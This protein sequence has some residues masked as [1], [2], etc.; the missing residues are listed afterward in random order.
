MYQY[1]A[2][3]SCKR[4]RYVAEMSHIYLVR[5]R[6]KICITFARIL[7][8]YILA[9]F[10]VDTHEGENKIAEIDEGFK[11]FTFPEVNHNYSPVSWQI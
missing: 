2:H 8:E 3:T 4:H 6:L 9:R 11:L 5:R 1:T 10:A 7:C